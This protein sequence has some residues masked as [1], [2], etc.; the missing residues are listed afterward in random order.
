[1]DFIGLVIAGCVGLVIVMVLLMFIF[2]SP[3][4]FGAL[5]VLLIGSY[6]FYLFTGE[7]EHIE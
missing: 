4:V 3:L 5:A 7:D 2:Q 1:M 6:L